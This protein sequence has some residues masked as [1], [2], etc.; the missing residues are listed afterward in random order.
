[1][2]HAVHDV[3]RLEIFGKA[4]PV[5][6]PDSAHP[7]HY[8]YPGHEELPHVVKFSGGQTSGMLLFVLLE[9][10]ILR[11][12]RGDV[13]I[14][15]NTSAEHPEKTVHI[16]FDYELPPGVDLMDEARVVSKAQLMHRASRSENQ[17]KS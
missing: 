16:K 17:R 3:P 4:R 6:S 11:P 13:V 7:F 1:M 14:F 2:T 9:A 15:N 10:G 5:S 8:E 12:E